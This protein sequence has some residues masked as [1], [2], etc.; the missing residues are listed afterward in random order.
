MVQSHGFICDIMI[1]VFPVH[2]Y[3]GPGRQRLHQGQKERES[4][5]WLWL[6]LCPIRLNLVI[7]QFT[8]SATSRAIGNGIIIIQVTCGWTW[9]TS[10]QPFDPLTKTWEI[11]SIYP[12]LHSVSLH[13]WLWVTFYTPTLNRILDGMSQDPSRAI[14]VLVCTSQVVRNWIVHCNINARD[15]NV[16]AKLNLQQSFQ[17]NF[18]CH[19]RVGLVIHGHEESGLDSNK[20]A[21]KHG[22]A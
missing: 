9:R 5:R 22:Q 2:K 16:C 1:D 6:F 18:N 12:H 10:S 13:L 15:F 14:L 21:G 11:V 7:C 3:V 8:S 4:E 20:Q 17:L 19:R